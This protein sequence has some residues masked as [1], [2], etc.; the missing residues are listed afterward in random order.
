MTTPEFDKAAFD[1]K[2]QATTAPIVE[3]VLGGRPVK[4]CYTFRAFHEMKL[5]PMR[6]EDVE[7]YFSDLSP[8][9]AAEWVAAGAR[10]YVR[11]MT[12]LA[13]QNGEAAPA[14]S[15]DDWTTESVL[16]VMDTVTF[17]AILEAIKDATGEPK[18]PA[19]A[20]ADPNQQ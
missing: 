10:G 15:A 13:R 2:L 1:K 9:R 16:D 19:E 5:N 3:I 8:E 6:K 7:A 20:T 18:K 14:E 11:L 12:Q 4:L 17:T